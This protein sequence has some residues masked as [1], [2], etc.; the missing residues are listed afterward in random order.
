MRFKLLIAGER[1]SN[2]SAGRP[3]LEL[4]APTHEVP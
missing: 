3:Q 1:D 2:D 4:G